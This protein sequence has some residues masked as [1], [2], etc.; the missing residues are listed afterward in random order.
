MNESTAP[1]EPAPADRRE[2]E[3]PIQFVA[4]GSEY[5]RIWS[6]NLLLILV[7]LGLYYPF[8][9]VRKLRYFHGCTEVGGRA[10]GFHADPWKMLRGFVLAGV[11]LVVYWVA[12]YYSPT[13]GLIALAIVCAVWPALWHSALRFRLANTSWRGLR[14]RFTGRVGG[15]YASLGGWFAWAVLVIAAFA[16]FGPEAPRVD[17]GQ[18]QMHPGALAVMVV[19]M[20]VPLPAFLWLMRRYQHRHY[21]L[22]REQTQFSV[23]LGRFYAVFGKAALLF[24]CML[25]VV[26]AVVFLAPRAFGPTGAGTDP[27]ARAM[28]V[29]V[30]AF[31]FVVFYVVSMAVVGALVAARLQDLCWTGTASPLISF[32]SRL[33]AIALAKLNLKNW[34]LIIVTLGLYFPFAAVA[35]ARLRLAAVT[36]LCQCSPDDLVAQA[37]AINESPA[38]DAAGD[39]LGIDVGL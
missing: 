2:H 11:M 5:F 20:L 39:L 19:L 25:T 14:F 18:P 23:S 28:A 1:V 7:T 24:C 29:A 36:V 10:L 27:G 38:G 12:G 8:A 22:G 4:S 34:L 16:I 6:V 17:N 30:G 32:Y 26:M 15:A 9:K 13:A 35:T 21:A 37:S 31:V 33:S 3:L